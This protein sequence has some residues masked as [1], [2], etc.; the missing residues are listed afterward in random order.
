MIRT[1]FSKCDLAE[2]VWSWGFFHYYFFFLRWGFAKVAGQILACLDKEILILFDFIYL[3]ERSANE[4]L[5][6]HRCPMYLSWRTGSCS[7]V[8]LKTHSDKNCVFCS[9]TCCCIFGEH[10][11]EKEAFEFFFFFIQ[12]IMNQEKMQLEEAC[13]GLLHRKCQA[14]VVRECKQRALIA[15]GDPS[16]CAAVKEVNSDF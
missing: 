7:C 11:Y 10:L 16:A 9:F 5:C 8:V 3:N 6:Q 4:P 2:F 12:I 1:D 15:L 13:S 14:G